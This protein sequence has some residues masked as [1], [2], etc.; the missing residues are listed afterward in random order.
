MSEY[1]YGVIFILHICFDNEDGLKA[2]YQ[3]IK[4]I[5]TQN[6]DK[7]FHVVNGQAATVVIMQ[8]QTVFLKLPSENIVAVYPVTNTVDGDKTT[9]H[10]FVPACAST[11]CKVQGQNLAKI[12]IWLDCPSVP[13][14]SAYVAL[15]CIT[16]LKDLYFVTKTDPEQYKATEHFAE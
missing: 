13:K 10:P 6:R 7:E 3:G 12:I 8:N 1:K 5:I 14:G 16:Q 9:C 11:I 4:V 15:S 2:V